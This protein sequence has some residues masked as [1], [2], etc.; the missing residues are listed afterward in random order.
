MLMNVINVH[1]W[2]NLKRFL[3]L[4]TKLNSVYRPA[5]EQF[6]IIVRKA[7]QHGFKFTKSPQ[8][9]DRSSWLPALLFLR[10]KGFKIAEP[11]KS[12][13]Q[14]GYAYDLSGPGLHAIEQGVRAAV[15]AGVIT[16]KRG[17]PRPILVELANHCVH[18]EI[19]AVVLLNSDTFDWC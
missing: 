9:S 6:D 14:K 19:E 8:L 4:G 15:K 7:H 3:P 10:K 13:H 16:L 2:N 12:A 1:V 5:Q 18:V 11:G 17:A